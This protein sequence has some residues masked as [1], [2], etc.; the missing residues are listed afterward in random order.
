MTTADSPRPGLLVPSIVAAGAFAVLI[1]LGTWQVERM[2]W[3]EALIA[4]VTERFGAPPIRLPPPTEWARLDPA[5]D[6]YRRVRFAAELLNDEEALVYT[7]GSSL[8]AGNSGPGYWVFAPAR[9]NGG[10]VMVNRGFVPEGRADPTMRAQGE[11]AGTFEIIGVMRWPERAGLFTPEAE[12]AKNLWF[13]RDP[14]A[15][16][17]AKGIGA[18]APFYVEQESPPAPGGFPQAGALKP[19]FPNNHFGYALTWYGLALV[20]AGSFAVWLVALRRG[21]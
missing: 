15:M 18:V 16:A 4:T 11:I 12:P 10:I 14:S 20:L 5:K 13:A 2:S 1:A 8:H 3:K 9:V 21:R 17:A 7:T 6:E 19:T